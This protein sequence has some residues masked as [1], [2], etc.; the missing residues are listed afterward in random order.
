MRKVTFVVS[1]LVVAALL[2]TPTAAAN[3][4]A[5][6]LEAW[7]LEFPPLQDAMTKK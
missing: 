4:L 5:H 7:T 1:I 2:A 6:T 3:Q